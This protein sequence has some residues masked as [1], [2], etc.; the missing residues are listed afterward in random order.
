[1]VFHFYLE[2]FQPR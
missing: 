1:L 2:I